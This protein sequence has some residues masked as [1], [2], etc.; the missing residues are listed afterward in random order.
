MNRQYAEATT[1][2]ISSC[3]AYDGL[4]TSLAA[5]EIFVFGSNLQGRHGA[6]TALV[7]KTKFAA[8]TGASWGHTGRCFALTAKGMNKNR[9]L[10]AETIAQN[11][12]K[13]YEAARRHSSYK[14][15][16]AYTSGTSRLLCGHSHDQTADVILQ[17][18]P[19]RRI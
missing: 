18:G 3:G 14:Y 12:K 13:L 17:A 9:G 1:A 11:Y 2:A 19:P 6:G 8:R 10:A 15:K 5:N 7:A 16:L 4:I